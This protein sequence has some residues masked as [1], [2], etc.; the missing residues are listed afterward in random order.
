MKHHVPSLKIINAVNIICEMVMFPWQI[1]DDDVCFELFPGDFLVQQS[2]SNLRINSVTDCWMV[3]LPPVEGQDIWRQPLAVYGPGWRDKNGDAVILESMDDL[4]AAAQQAQDS[5]YKQVAEDAPV[6]ATFFLR[7]HNVSM[8]A[9]LS[10]SGVVEY[11][12]HPV[13]A[14]NGA[15]ATV[16]TVRN[17]SAIPGTLADWAKA[18]AKQAFLLSGTSDKSAGL[19]IPLWRWFTLL[20]YL[21]RVGKVNL[22]AVSQKRTTK[23]AAKIPTEPYYG[24]LSGLNLQLE[25]TNEKLSCDAS[26][27]L[28]GVRS[29]AYQKAYASKNAFYKWESADL[30]KVLEDAVEFSN[31]L[32]SEEGKKWGGVGTSGASKK[33]DQQNTQEAEPDDPDDPTNNTEEAP[34]TPSELEEYN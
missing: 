14:K 1:W 19:T 11:L 25:V 24:L 2:Y 31:L 7:T 22:P 21:G 29:E 8:P 28:S 9:W 5:T 26:M 32:L 20:P 13:A 4:K 12:E 33:S 15:G 3:S 16:A 17:P 6:A 23:D 30:A 10:M 34:D 18:V 27:K